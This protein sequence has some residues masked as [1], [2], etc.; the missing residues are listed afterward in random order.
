MIDRK[1]LLVI[2]GSV[3]NV[4]QSNLT[5]PFIS[6]TCTPMNWGLSATRSRNSREL[7]YPAVFFIEQ[8]VQPNRS[9]FQVSLFSLHK[10][11]P[12]PEPHVQAYFGTS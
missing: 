8:F 11:I 12:L 5:K 7:E 10:N 3:G 2:S 9:N 1:L 4:I 6:C